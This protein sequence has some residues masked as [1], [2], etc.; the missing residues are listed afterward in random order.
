[1]DT[2]ANK[3][4]ARAGRSWNAFTCCVELCWRHAMQRVGRGMQRVGRGWNAVTW[5]LKALM[6]ENGY[7]QYLRYHLSSGC[8]SPPLSEK[9]F[10]KDKMDW[11]DKNPQGRCC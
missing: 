4:L 6:G 5:Y 7:E 8:Q 10:W 1:M 2:L 11:Q 9:Q 3:S